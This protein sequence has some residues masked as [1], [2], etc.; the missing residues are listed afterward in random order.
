MD[1][2]GLLQSLTDVLSAPLFDMG[3]QP[4]S[5]SLIGA[6]VI[7]LGVSL[8]A[9]R[10]AGRAIARVLSARPD[11]RPATTYAITRLAHYLLVTIGFLVALS[12]VGIDLTSITVIAGALGVGIGFGLQSIVSNFVSGLILLFEGNVK[13]GDFV[14][15]AS[16]LSGHVRAINVRST[17]IV[18]HDNLDV[19]VPNSELVSGQ[20]INWTMSDAIVRFKVPFGVA[21][22][23]NKEI[24]TQAVM[25]A[26]AKLPTTVTEPAPA[27]PPQLWLVGFGDS[28]LDFELVVWVDMGKNKAPGKIIPSYLWEIESS[29]REHQVEIPFPQRDLHL[30]SGWQK[31]SE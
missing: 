27:R 17:H 4:V 16:G 14:E 6:F 26:A 1:T 25:E 29:L 18:T 3:G 10:L 5:L 8:V 30:R 9:S 23:S 19:I 31:L 11:L 24:V 13:V 20:L 15:I 28:S 21:Y 12:V 7:V 22:G 2:D